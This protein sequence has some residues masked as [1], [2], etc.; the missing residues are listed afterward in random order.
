MAGSAP[1]RRHKT[2]ENQGNGDATNNLQQLMLLSM[3][4]FRHFHCRNINFGRD[5]LRCYKALYRIIT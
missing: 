1:S 4:H 3:K 2:Q 5:V